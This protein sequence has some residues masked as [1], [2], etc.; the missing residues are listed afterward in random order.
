[1]YFLVETNGSQ[2]H[3]EIAKYIEDYLENRYGYT[4]DFCVGLS[5]SPI[6][7]YNEHNEPIASFISKP[8]ESVLDFHMGLA[9]QED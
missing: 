9:I 1:M 4:V 5:S 7:I 3:H 2:E 8:E 6:S